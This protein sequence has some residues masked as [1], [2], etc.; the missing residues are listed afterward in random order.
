MVY[1]ATAPHIAGDAAWAERIERHRRSRP[2]AWRSVEAPLELPAA[3]R[4]NAA[5]SS[6]MLVDCLTL[7]LSN[8]VWA[9]RDPAAAGDALCLALTELP[10]DTVAVSN[11]VGLCVHPESEP[12]RVFRDA[13]GLLNQRVAA[14]ADRV[15]LVVAGLVLALKEVPRPPTVETPSPE[16][17]ADSGGPAVRPKRLAADPAQ[18]REGEHGVEQ[19]LPVVE[20]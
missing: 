7:W 9:G 16:S 2:A 10:G 15:E 20:V 5:P 19:G 13:Q 6:C 17:A 18:P 8:L 3:L 4:A 1:I 11:E 12:G 14:L